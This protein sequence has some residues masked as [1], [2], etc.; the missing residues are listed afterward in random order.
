M[1]TTTAKLKTVSGFSLF[2][3]LMFIAVL[4]IMI[5]IAIPVFATTDGAKQAT[6][7]QNAQVICT[8]ATAASASGVNV[9]SGTTDVLKAMSKMVEGVTITKGPLK[10]KTFRTPNISANELKRASAYVQIKNGELLIAS[11]PIKT[12][13]P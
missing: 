2:E 7:R 5:S 1:K 6:D 8:L 3:V 13:L 11:G 12:E 10:N 4:G 9:A